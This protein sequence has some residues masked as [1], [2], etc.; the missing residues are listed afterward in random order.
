MASVPNRPYPLASHSEHVVVN[1]S[2]TNVVAS[3]TV[4][5]ANVVA[6][7]SSNTSSGSALIVRGNIALKG[8]VTTG[9]IS[10]GNILVLAGAND[11]VTTGSAIDQVIVGVAAGAVTAGAAVDVYREG[12]ATYISSGSITRGALVGVNPQGITRVQQNTSGSCVLGIALNSANA[13][14][15]LRVLIQP[16]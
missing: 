8:F 6:N 1:L 3:T 5:G 10:A 13:E 16:Q 11:T 4:S 2:A 7:S 12:I 15:T 14:G 9:S